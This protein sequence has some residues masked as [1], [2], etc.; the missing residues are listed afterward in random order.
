MVS[1]KRLLGIED[2]ATFITSV[3]ILSHPSLLSAP[4][5]HAQDTDKRDSLALSRD[6]SILWKDGNSSVSTVKAVLRKPRKR[7][8][9]HLNFL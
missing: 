9:P 5:I 1:L 3:L 2:F 7:E 6:V 8:L 4:H